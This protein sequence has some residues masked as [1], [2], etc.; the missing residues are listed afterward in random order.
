MCKRVRSDMKA[1]L[2]KKVSEIKVI[3]ETKGTGFQNISLKILLRPCYTKS[4]NQ[5]NWPIQDDLQR[6][7]RAPEGLSGLY[8]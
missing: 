8:S 3:A 1:R 2:L 4:D 6:M 5:E 7:L